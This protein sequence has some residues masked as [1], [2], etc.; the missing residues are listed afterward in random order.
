[1]IIGTEIVDRFY[2][3]IVIVQ[4]KKWEKELS[5]SNIPANKSSLTASNKNLLKS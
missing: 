4:L 2:G 1:M 3:F 5:V